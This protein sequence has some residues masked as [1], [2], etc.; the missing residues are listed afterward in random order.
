MELQ[1]EFTVPA[2]VSEVWK[3]L[4]DVERIAPCLPGATVDRHEGDEVAG[5]VN[6]KVGP[7]TASY[8]GTAKFVTKDESEH[9][10]VLRASGRETRGSGSAAATVE[11]RMSEQESGTHVTV[12]TSL[13][14]SGKQAQFGR[15]V[16][17]EVAG[18]LTD[19]FAACLAQRVREPAAANGHAPAPAPARPVAQDG[20]QAAAQ[21]EAPQASGSLD[22]ISTV[23]GP[24]AKQFAPVLAGLTLGVV[25]GFLLGHRRRLTVVVAPVPMPSPLGNKAGM[26]VALMPRQRP[27]RG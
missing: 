23:A 24:L 2:P 7:I 14:I 6:V 1:N 15:G 20:D 13:Q 18:K 9:R 26:A 27:R 5:R 11:A 22:I 4:L 12:G 8:A 19:Q 3:T 17:A 21:A 25:L 16:M 10:F